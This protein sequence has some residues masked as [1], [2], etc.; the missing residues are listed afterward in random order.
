MTTTFISD[1]HLDAGRPKTVQTFLDFT[2]T[3]A[4]HA[5]ALYILGDLFEMWI[6]DDDIEPSNSRVMEALA[7]VAAAGVPCF[8]MHGNRDFLIGSA[9]FAATG[10]ELIE[11]PKIVEIEGNQVLLT[12][13]DVLCTDDKPYQELRRI[14]RNP[15]WQQ[16]FLSKTLEERRAMAKDLRNQSL[17]ETAAKPEDIM[18]VNQCAVKTMMQEHNVKFLIHGHTHRP[19]VH[20]FVLDG[21]QATRVVLG[22]WHEKG[23]VL[24]WNTK[25]FQ[26]KTFPR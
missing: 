17:T 16:N 23:S 8:Y 7:E 25:G 15:Y 10:G 13:G 4:I 18:D 19:G 11:D 6:G 26:L 24:C 3:E 12:H 1:L 5:N 14:V 22:A 20:S 21:H 9:F 2:R